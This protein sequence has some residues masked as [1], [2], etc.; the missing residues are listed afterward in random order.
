MSK[1]R[2]Y[3]QLHNHTHTHTHTQITHTNQLTHTHTHTNTCT[4]HVRMHINQSRFLQEE[5]LSFT[6]DSKSRQS[7]QSSWEIPIPWQRCR[8]TAW[9]TRETK[10]SHMVTCQV[11]CAVKVLVTTKQSKHGT[12]DH[13]F[14][15][16]NKWRRKDPYLKQPLKPCVTS[17]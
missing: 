2:T 11:S 8:C 6:L 3:K 17:T 9:P 15:Q 16:A 10:T 1:V 5:N 14:K 12:Q 7:S 13:Y 4:K